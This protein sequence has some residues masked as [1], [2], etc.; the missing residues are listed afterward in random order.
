MHLRL[1]CQSIA[2]RLQR[3]SLRGNPVAAKDAMLCWATVLQLSP[4]LTEFEGLPVTAGDRAK[5]QAYMDELDE[6]ST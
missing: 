1:T 2:Q 6:L 5:A 3:L 4:A